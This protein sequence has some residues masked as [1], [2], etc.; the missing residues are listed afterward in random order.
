MSLRI[1]EVELAHETH[2]THERKTNLGTAPATQERTHLPLH[3]VRISSSVFVCF[4]CFVGTHFFG[5][6]SRGLR[7]HW[8]AAAARVL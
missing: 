7:N 2:E 3:P 8:R 5:R 4:V 6:V 1:I